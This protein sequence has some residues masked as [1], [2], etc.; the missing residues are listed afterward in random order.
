MHLCGYVYMQGYKDG[1]LLH[2]YSRQLLLRDDIFLKDV[3]SLITPSKLQLLHLP[4]RYF[5]LYE[6]QHDYSQTATIALT[7]QVQ[8]PLQSAIRPF[9]HCNHCIYLMGIMPFPST[10]KQFTKC[11]QWS[12]Q[13]VPYPFKNGTDYK[14]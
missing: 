1:G 8:Y 14:L 2:L 7:Q 9:L 4:N 11:N 5:T 10:P 3:I 6:V 12:C 13:R